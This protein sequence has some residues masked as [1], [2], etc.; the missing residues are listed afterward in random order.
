MM[1]KYEATVLKCS[2][3][4]HVNKTKYYDYVMR[5]L[6]SKRSYILLGLNIVEKYGYVRICSMVY[7][8]VDG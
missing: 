3:D 7:F 6:R 4:F 8:T 2:E 5:E 1:E